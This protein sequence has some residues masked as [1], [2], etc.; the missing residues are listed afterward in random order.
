M[1]VNL[2]LR[3]LVGSLHGF[4]DLVR[5]N[6]CGLFVSLRALLCVCQFRCGGD[7]SV[8]DVVSLATLSRYR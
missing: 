4:E 6:L 8:C 5:A 2:F 3:Y 7:G 1:G